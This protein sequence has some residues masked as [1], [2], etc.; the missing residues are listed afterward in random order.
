MTTNKGLEQFDSLSVTLRQLLY[1]IKC[2]C[3]PLIHWDQ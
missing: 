2:Y 3:S 1:K